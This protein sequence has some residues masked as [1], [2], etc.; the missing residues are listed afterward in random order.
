MKEV[1]VPERRGSMVVLTKRASEE[2]V[3]DKPARVVFLETGP[4]HV[5]VG[6]L[7]TDEGVEECWRA[8]S[9]DAGRRTVPVIAPYGEQIEIE[10]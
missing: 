8:T 2:V 6:V 7:D 5:K 3:I 9:R 10:G 1:P 4:D